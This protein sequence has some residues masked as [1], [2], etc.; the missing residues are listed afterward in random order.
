MTDNLTIVLTA[1]IVFGFAFLS[2]VFFLAA[3]VEK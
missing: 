3:K 1:F 2:L